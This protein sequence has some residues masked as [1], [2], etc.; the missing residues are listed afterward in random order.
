MVKI[1][2]TSVKHFSTQSSPG[3]LLCTSYS[4]EI[5]EYAVICYTLQYQRAGLDGWLVL[6]RKGWR[7]HSYP[8]QSTN[9]LPEYFDKKRTHLSSDNKSANNNRYKR[10]NILLFP[11][12]LNIEMLNATKDT[13]M[14]FSPVLQGATSVLANGIKKDDALL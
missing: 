9:C 4:C 10:R 6:I 14:Y 11:W 3:I 8:S 12:E 2:S 1:L 13:Y 5:T 7:I